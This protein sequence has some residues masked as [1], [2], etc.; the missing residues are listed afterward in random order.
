MIRAFLAIQPAENVLQSLEALQVELGETGADARWVRREAMHL[1]IQFLGDV[2]E[3]ELPQI[4]SGLGEALCEQQPF[5]IECRG[6]GVFPN[7]KRPRVVWVGLRG[8][9][10]V[11]LAERTETVL[12]PLG[13]PPEERDLTPHI[14]LGRVRSMRGWEGLQRVLKVSGERSFGSSTIDHA[15]LYRS[16]L[17]PDHAVYTVIAEFPFAR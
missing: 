6:L 3:N 9:G 7:Q 14:T 12:S 4:Q 5:E 1:T 15:T 11:R 2:R 8:E 13:F 17:R 16:E 10:L